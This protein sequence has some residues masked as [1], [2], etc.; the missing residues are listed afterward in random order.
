MAVLP[1]D[2]PVEVEL[3]AEVGDAP[4]D[5]GQ[6]WAGRGRRQSGQRRAGLPGDTRRPAI[7]RLP[8]ALA[9]QARRGPERPKEPVTPRDAASVL[10]PGRRRGGPGPAASRS[11][12]SAGPGPWPSPPAFRFPRRLR[13]PAGR[14]GGH[15][16]GRAGRAGTGPGPRRSRR[17]G[18]GARRA[19]VRETFEESGVLLAGP[20]PRRGGGHQRPGLGGGPA[21][22]AGSF[23]VPG[24]L[25]RPPRP[26]AALDLLRPWARW[27]TP[28]SRPAATTPGSSS[29]PS[30]PASGPGMS[31]ARLRRWPGGSR[32]R[33]SPPAA[34]RELR[35][36]PPTAVCLAQVG[37]AGRSMRRCG[38]PGPA[39]GDPR[40]RRGRRY[41][42]G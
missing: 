38:P 23:A 1:L 6:R 2:A 12:C 11:T 16:L 18:A 30:R 31:A 21:G 5:A 24:W 14:R 19:A 22:P 9:G 3:I 42:C 37:R 10:L 32:T 25:P 40:G 13:G 7:L 36:M 27:I 29:P 17:A 20:A 8:G 41:R 28:W 26:G 4:R 39:A 34:P 15:G 33:R 35:L